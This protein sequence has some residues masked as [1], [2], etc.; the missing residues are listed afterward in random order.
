MFHD[1]QLPF[2]VGE[3]MQSLCQMTEREKNPGFSRTTG[4]E[5]MMIQFDEAWGH[6]C[7]RRMRSVSAN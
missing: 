1:W 2:Q 6:D 7:D 3:F 5:S 4:L